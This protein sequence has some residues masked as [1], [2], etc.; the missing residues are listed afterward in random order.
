MSCSWF[1]RR[2]DTETKP[3]SA[4]PAR[5]QRNGSKTSWLKLLMSFVAAQVCNPDALC[6]GAG[7]ALFPGCIPAAPRLDLFMSVAAV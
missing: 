2:T 4:E 7:C 3:D 6:L 5:G 1:G